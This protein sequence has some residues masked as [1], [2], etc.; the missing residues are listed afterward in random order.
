MNRNPEPGSAEEMDAEVV[1]ASSI[2]WMLYAA[3]FC[4][5]CGPVALIL[6]AICHFNK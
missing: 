4:L 6:T 3:G 5:L 2:G 1:A